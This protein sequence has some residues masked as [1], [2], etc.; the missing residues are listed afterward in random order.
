METYNK[1]E[2]KAS[3]RYVLFDNENIISNNNIRYFIDKSIGQG[4]YSN[5]FN[6][7]KSSE[8]S[9]IDTKNEIYHPRCIKIFKGTDV[10]TDFGKREAIMLNKIKDS[11]FFVSL[12]VSFM[13]QSHFCIITN[14]YDLNLYQAIKECYLCRNDIKYISTQILKGL[15]FLK[16]KTIIHGDLKPENI[17][18]N[19]KENTITSCVICDFN[20]AIDLS[21]SRINSK[22]SNISTLWYRAPEIYLDMDYSYEIDMWAFGCILYEL[23]ARTPL[24]YPRLDNDNNLNNKRLHEQHLSFIGRCPFETLEN[25]GIL[26][27][28]NKIKF[29]SKIFQTGFQIIFSK[30]I[31]WEPKKRILPQE[32]LRIFV[33]NI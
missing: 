18:V 31:H 20:L 4:S 24:F 7:Q 27:L 14:K 5:I 15:I 25:Y 9:N 22:D 33:D 13:Y 32:A 1:Y 10:Y 21:K 28:S 23:V 17:L 16:E 3:K 2:K 26:D 19:H 6:I 12:S 29:N 11:T 8:K 30:C